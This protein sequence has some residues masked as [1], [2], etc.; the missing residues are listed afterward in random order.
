M[1][2]CRR[3]VNVEVATARRSPAPP[4]V[5]A[6]VERE[7]GLE[8]RGGLCGLRDRA[9]SG[10]GRGAD[11]EEADGCERLASFVADELA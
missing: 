10:D 2:S 6:A 5:W 9:L 11:A 1:G 3:L 4:P 7:R 8:G